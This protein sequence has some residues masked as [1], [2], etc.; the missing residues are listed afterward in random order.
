MKV[1]PNPW[2]VRTPWDNGQFPEIT[3]AGAAQPDRQV[4][5]EI[6]RESGTDSFIRVNRDRLSNRH[7]SID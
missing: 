4:A 3:L 5:M 6:E 1:K 2:F 7:L